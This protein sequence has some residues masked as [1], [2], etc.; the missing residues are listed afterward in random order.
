[1]ILSSAT[2]A[3]DTALLVDTIR[4]AVGRADPADGRTDRVYRDGALDRE[5]W[6]V[7]GRE[8]GIGALAVPENLGGSAPPSPPWPPFSKPSV[9]N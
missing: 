5:L 4:A 8:I 7:L 6:S 3:E 9:R 2:G 1:M